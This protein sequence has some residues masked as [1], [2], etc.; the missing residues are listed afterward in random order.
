MDP[1]GGLGWGVG[2]RACRGRF[3]ASDARFL[4]VSSG[5]KEPSLHFELLL[6]WPFE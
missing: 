4:A 6:A 2:L 5:V 3:E 1:P